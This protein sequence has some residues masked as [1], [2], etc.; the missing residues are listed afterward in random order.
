[1]AV[2]YPSA[3]ATLNKWSIVPGFFFC[4]SSLPIYLLLASAQTKNCGENHWEAKRW[5]ERCAVACAS[6]QMDITW[7]SESY[8]VMGVGKCTL[9]V[10]LSALVV[11]SL[12]Q[13]W[14]GAMKWGLN[15]LSHFLGCT[16]LWAAATLWAFKPRGWHVAMGALQVWWRWL[17]QQQHLRCTAQ[18]IFRPRYP[19]QREPG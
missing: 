14:N 19:T 3:G 11:F 18:G 8:F 4:F 12:A 7:R 9:L 2:R 6:D 16:T 1:M 10:S 13:S 15:A 5:Y 17:L